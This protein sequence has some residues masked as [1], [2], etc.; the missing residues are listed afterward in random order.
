MIY[1]SSLI[2]NGWWKRCHYDGGNHCINGNALTPSSDGVGGGAASSHTPHGFDLNLPTLLIEISR[3][4]LSSWWT[5]RMC[6]GKLRHRHQ[7]VGRSFTMSYRL[8]NVI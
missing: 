1:C 5:L 3:S 4:K 2:C 8:I 6:S 7:N